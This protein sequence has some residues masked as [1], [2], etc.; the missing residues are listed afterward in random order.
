[1]PGSTSPLQI[2]PRRLRIAS[3]ACVLVVAISA[4][5]SGGQPA[6]A[7]DAGVDEVHYTLTGPTS[8]AFDWR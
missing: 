7:D 1:M 4:L 6:G 8:V 5:L 3:A 2:S